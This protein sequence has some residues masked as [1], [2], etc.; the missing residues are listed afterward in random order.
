MSSGLILITGGTGF[1]GGHVV[2]QTLEA[3]YRA[4]LVVRREESIGNFKKVFS[5][6][7]SQLDFVVI[8]DFTKDGAFSDA[9]V[10]VDYIFHLASPIP[11]RGNDFK[12]DY[13]APAT[14]GTISL[15]EA[16]QSVPSIKRVVI[17]SS[18]G[19]LLPLDLSDVGSLEIKEGINRTIPIHPDSPLVTSPSAT[20]MD[21]YNTSKVLA[22][23]ACLDWVD[24]QS[25]AGALPFAVVT[26]HPSVVVGRHLL[27]PSPADPGSSNALLWDSLFAPAA[28][29]PMAGVDV[30]DVASAH[31]RALRP[32]DAELGEKGRVAEF[33]ISAPDWTWQGVVDFVKKKYPGLGVTLDGSSGPDFKIRTERAE[34]VLGIKWRPLEDAVG[35]LVD[36]QIEIGVAKR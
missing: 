27:Q 15:L 8:R 18:A 13:L 24:Q 33:V 1:I 14:K 11:G 35:E 6:H 7:F 9:L 19:A 28:L 31:V 10:G 26:L 2:Q 30:R 17:D 20:D 16:A 22:H 21:K 36:Q 23:R 32:A 29:I 3:G 25:A 12:E 5:K 34:K 4:R